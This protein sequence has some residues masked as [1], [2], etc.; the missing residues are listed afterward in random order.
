MDF[1][2]DPVRDVVHH[3]LGDQHV[4]PHALMELLER[5]HD[6]RQHHVRQARRCREP[7]RPA[8]LPM[9]AG[10]DVL[11]RL[12]DLDRSPRLLQHV[13]AERRQAKAARRALQQLQ[14]ELGFELRDPSAHRRHRHAQPS[15]R[16]RKAQRVGDVREHQQRLEVDHLGGADDR[17][18]PKP[19]RARLDIPAPTSLRRP[20][21]TCSHPPTY[22]T[23]A[24]ATAS[25]SHSSCFWN[26]PFQRRVYRARP[27]RIMAAP[28]RTGAETTCAA[29]RKP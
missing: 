12:R 28:V 14:A 29:F 19:V 9:V 26:N 1:Q 6:Q 7:D 3:L 2:I 25:R 21:R 22:T 27:P 17:A 13:A 18:D 16:R 10:G 8:H 20:A 4:E 5:E 23:P 24:P 15:R 11:D